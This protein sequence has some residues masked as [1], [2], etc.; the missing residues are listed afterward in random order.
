M[1]IN[2]FTKI[3]SKGFLKFGIPIIFLLIGCVIGYV[4]QDFRDA[5]KDDTT[6]LEEREG[7]YSLINPLLECD[8]KGDALKSKEL[9][10]FKRDVADFIKKDLNKNWA[11]SISLYFRELNNGIWFSI[12]ETEKFI[13][14]SLRKVP[15]MIAIL[16]QA[17]TNS[18][19]LA[20]KVKFQLTSDYNAHQNIKPSKVLTP[21]YEYTVEDL[22][23]QMI[24]YSD[25]NAFTL[26]A[27][28]VDAAELQKVYYLLNAGSPGTEGR[29]DF[30][31]FTYASFFRILYNASYLNR[32]MSNKALEYMSNVEFKSGIVAGV[33][34][35][36]VVAHKFG[37]QSDEKTNIKQ[38]HDCGIVYHPRHPYLLCVMSKGIDF[39]YLDDAIA[40]ISHIIYT[41]VD[42][43]F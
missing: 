24:T 34:S 14:A 1:P 5:G 20:R 12:G 19:I 9:R 31:V 36:I 39:K 29:D 40:S 18:N 11:Q 4:I 15:L 42:E 27:G 33:P 30:S 3:K 16:K 37:E 10:P 23:Y 21:G 38:L 41:H 26:L 7:S 8:I 13:P 43:Q 22:I 2:C 6:L 17:E 28:V 32:N 25:N 35:G